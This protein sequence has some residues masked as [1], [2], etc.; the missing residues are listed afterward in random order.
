[1]D[2]VQ[3]SLRQ[4]PL[5]NDAA[6][7]RRHVAETERPATK[8]LL[9]NLGECVAEFALPLRTDALQ[10]HSHGGRARGQHTPDLTCRARP[11]R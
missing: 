1:M 10:E 9:D 5:A 4:L 7:D 11:T 3:A 2:L 8:P 6:A